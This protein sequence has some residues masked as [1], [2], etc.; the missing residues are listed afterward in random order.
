MTESK[1]NEKKRV[2]GKAYMA[3]APCHVYTKYK[4]APLSLTYGLAIELHGGLLGRT[5]SK[6]S[7]R[8]VGPICTPPSNRP[9]FASPSAPLLNTNA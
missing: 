4:S 8:Q 9:V 7:I 3:D 2:H 5:T 6:D 1:M